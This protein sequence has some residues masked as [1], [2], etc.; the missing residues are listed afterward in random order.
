MIVDSVPVN[1]TLTGPFCDGFLPTFFVVCLFLKVLNVAAVFL[2][3]QRHIRKLVNEASSPN[4]L[5]EQ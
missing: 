2:Y 1:N 5:A 4:V 3:F